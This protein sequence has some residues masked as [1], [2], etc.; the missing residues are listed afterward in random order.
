MKTMMTLTRAGMGALAGLVLLALAAGSAFAGPLGQFGPAGAAAPALTRA[1][2]ALGYPDASAK[3]DRCTD[4][5]GRA[6]CVY[7]MPD[8]VAI[9]T[10]G[11]AADQPP[12]A[13]QVMTKPSTKL[14]STAATGLAIMAMVDPQIDEAEAREQM[15]ALFLSIDPD[16]NG[17][18]SASIHETANARYAAY[19]QDDALLMTILGK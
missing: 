11:P 13:L 12:R 6:L 19:L 2:A 16:G 14:Q 15:K 17:R 7:V 18:E 9:I 10:S 8:D 1:F 4:Q 3:L 5:Q